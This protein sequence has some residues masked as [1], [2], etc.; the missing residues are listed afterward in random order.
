MTTKKK[1]MLEYIAEELVSKGISSDPESI[2]DYIGDSS[3]LSE[4]MYDYLC[5][6]NDG[7]RTLEAFDQPG[8]E[9]ALSDIS[10]YMEEIICANS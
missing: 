2:H 5:N 3:S 7:Y 6:R 8:Y 10:F 4:D 1:S 9:D